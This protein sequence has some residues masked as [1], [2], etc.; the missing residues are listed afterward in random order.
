MCPR[1]CMWF[2]ETKE[3]PE[4]RVQVGKKDPRGAL[5]CLEIKVSLD[6][7]RRVL[8]HPKDTKLQVHVF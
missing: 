7:F 3:Q 2:V 8:T 1:Q 6:S 4:S 5:G